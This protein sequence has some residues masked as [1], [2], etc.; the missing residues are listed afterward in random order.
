MNVPGICEVCLLGQIWASVSKPH[1]HLLTD[2]SEANAGNLK[3]YGEFGSEP[4]MIHS[5]LIQCSLSIISTSFL[6][7]KWSGS[8]AQ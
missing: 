7:P 1:I 2:P 8:D 5:V 4:I 6:F 3:S